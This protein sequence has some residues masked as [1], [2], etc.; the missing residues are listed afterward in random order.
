M[1][2]ITYET[3]RPG[4]DIRDLL[5]H[6]R[7]HGRSFGVDVNGIGLWS[8][9]ANTPTAL[10]IMTSDASE[11]L[12][13]AVVYYGFM[14]TADGLYRSTIDSLAH[15]YGY[16]SPPLSDIGDA[17]SDLPLFIVQ[18]GRDQFP[19]LNDSIAHFIKRATA[20]NTPFVYVNY[21]Q[22]HHAFD[23]TD[24]SEQSRKIIKMTLEFLRANL[25][26]NEY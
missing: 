12:R 21:S 13:C 6:I 17:S 2:G 22:G 1:I 9:S 8:C 3:E 20:R 18:A 26:G 5:C 16:Y 11:Y 14:P 25:I 24:N 10:S 4:E 19:H 7:R 15:V 23:V